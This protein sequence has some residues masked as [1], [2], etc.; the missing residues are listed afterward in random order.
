MDYFFPKAQADLSS[1]AGT[2]SLWLEHR[3]HKVEFRIVPPGGK[4]IITELA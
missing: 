4:I 1:I 3:H 2:G